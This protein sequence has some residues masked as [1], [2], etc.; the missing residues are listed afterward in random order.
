METKLIKQEMLVLPTED[1][2]E[3]AED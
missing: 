2:P 3:D 1:M